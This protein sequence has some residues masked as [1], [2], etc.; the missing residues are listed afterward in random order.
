MAAL[1]Q[2]FGTGTAA[3]NV[4]TDTGG[5]DRRSSIYRPHAAEEGVTFSEEE[6]VSAEKGK[7]EDGIFFLCVHQTR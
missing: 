7:E 4:F 2:M 6:D 1:V 3:E 5:H